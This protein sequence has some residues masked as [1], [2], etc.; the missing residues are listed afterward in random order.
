MGYTT[1]F[2]GAFDIEPTLKDDHRAYLVAFSQTRHMMRDTSK[3]EGMPDPLRKAVGLPLGALGE[4]FIGEVPDGMQYWE[5]ESNDESILDQ[6]NEAPS[7]PGLWCN[8][9]PTQDGAA[10]RWDGGEKFYNYIEWL[11]Y[12]IDN[13]FKPWGYVLNGEVEWQGE[14]RDDQGRIV[15]KENKVTILYPHITWVPM[16]P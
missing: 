11:N 6:N 15:V 14:E 3:L 4:F 10:L 2:Y 16:N 13:F 8:W 1:D 7:Q 12:L 9:E 5:W